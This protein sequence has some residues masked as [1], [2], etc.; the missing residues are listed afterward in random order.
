MDPNQLQGKVAIITGSSSGMGR[1]TAVKLA[2]LGAAVVCCDLR[3]E[4]NPNGYEDDVN[5]TTVDKIKNSGGKASFVKVDIS[6]LKE[7][8]AAFAHAINV[9]ADKPCGTEVF[10]P[11]ADTHDRSTAASIFRLTAQAIGHLSSSF[12]KKMMSFGTRWQ[13]STLWA[14]RKLIAWRWRSF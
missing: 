8:E 10:G 9:R 3:A 13:G 5:V 4:S 12:K 6:Q 11:K 14:L 7:V 2:K 1:C